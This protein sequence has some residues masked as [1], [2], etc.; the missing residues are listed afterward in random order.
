MLRIDVRTAQDKR[1]KIPA[2]CM[3]AVETGRNLAR[4]N[5]ITEDLQA[6]QVMSACP[7]A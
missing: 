6:L 4:T 2:V 3:E 1:F 7:A 5:Q